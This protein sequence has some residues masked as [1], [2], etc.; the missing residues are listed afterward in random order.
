MPHQSSLNKTNMS[1]LPQLGVELGLR[2]E[3]AIVPQ[4]T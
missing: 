4:L 1:L 3:G 2:A